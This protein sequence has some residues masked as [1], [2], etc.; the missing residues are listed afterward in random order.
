MIPYKASMKLDYEACRPMELPAIYD[1]PISA[2]S[3]AGYDMT[4]TRML[5]AQLHF[6]DRRSTR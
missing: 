2:A 3:A 6:L 5:A 1:S 4:R